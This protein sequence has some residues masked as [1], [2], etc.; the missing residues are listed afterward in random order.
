MKLIFDGHLDLA[1]NALSWNRDLKE[2]IARINQ[3]E[4]RMTQPCR[5]KAAVSFA[6]MRR[7]GVALCLTTVLARA[8]RRFCPAG[9]HLRTD[10]DHGTQET[11][12]AVAQGQPSYYRLMEAEGRMRMIRDVKSLDAHWR[13][14][15]G[16]NHR[17][18]PIGFILLME[19]ADPIL[20]PAHAESWWEDGLRVVG[21]SHYGPGV[22]ASGTGSK[23]SLTKRGREILKEFEHL[24][25]IVDV[26]HLSDAAFFET[27]KRFEG[28]V[29]ASHTNCRALTPGVRQFS[30]EQIRLI[31]ERDGVIGCVLHCGMLHPGW[32]WKNPPRFRVGLEAVVNHMDHIC[33]IAGNA[34]HVAIG[35]DLDGGFGTEQCPREISTIA[36]MQ[37]L[38]L[39][40]CR[41]GY[42]KEDV[43]RI[44]HGNWLG[45]FRRAWR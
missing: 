33:Q 18:L 20:S 34:L 36:D 23:S 27:L 31:I 39:I 14:W 25:M 24:G 19:S 40:L 43:D 44:F 5:G 28:R 10:L 32:K 21:L 38:D 45:F 26:S 30:D 22:Y 3:R 37:K 29:L 12:C 11:A 17:N 8:R 2:S 42:R 41:R 4:I 16:G 35:S 6:E 9:G 13:Q 7:G 15:S 1:W